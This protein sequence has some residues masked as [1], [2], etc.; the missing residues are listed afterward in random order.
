MTSSQDGVNAAIVLIAN[1]L[2]FNKW[3]AAC[4]C[5]LGTISGRAEFPAFC[6]F[7]QRRRVGLPIVQR[8]WIKVRAVGPDDGAGFW[9][10]PNLIEKKPDRGV[11]RR[12]AHAAEA[13]S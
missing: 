2:Q 6:Q 3:C 10:N 4:K 8:G 9:I 13:R 5:Y 11:V 7:D 1:H 12:G